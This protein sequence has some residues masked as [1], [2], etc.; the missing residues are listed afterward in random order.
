METLDG[1]ERGTWEE[2]KP[3]PCARDLGS[4]QWELKQET[5]WGKA[6]RVPGGQ[7]IVTTKWGYCCGVVSI[8]LF[9]LLCRIF[10]LLG[11]YYSHFCNWKGNK[12]LG[13]CRAM[14]CRGKNTEPGDGAEAPNVA[15]P[16]LLVCKI[17]GLD[18]DFLFC[19]LCNLV[20]WTLVSMQRGQLPSLP[21]S[22]V[23][24]RPR[25]LLEWLGLSFWLCTRDSIAS[26]FWDGD[27]SS[28]ASLYTV[29]ES[30]LGDRVLDEVE[31]DSFIAW[32]GKEGHSKLMPP[33]TKCPNLGKIVTSF[34]IIAQ[35]GCDQFVD[36]L[37]MGCWWGK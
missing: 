24:L 32:S 12:S 5:G 30:N 25:I 16:R 17:R 29:A 26:L 18:M 6:C 31:K 22:L 23:S 34:I 7:V 10:H 4:S 36:F 19:S 3:S 21:R 33:R 11:T 27:A 9:H 13:Q 2:M 15:E 20:L 1:Y 37:L 35:R 8:L 14:R 28:L